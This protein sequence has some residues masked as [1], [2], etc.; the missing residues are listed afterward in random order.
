MSSLWGVHDPL[1]RVPR[2]HI[3]CLDSFQTRSDFWNWRIW[4]TFPCLCYDMQFKVPSLAD[5]YRATE[6]E[7]I[8]EKQRKR[9]RARE[10]NVPFTM[11]QSLFPSFSFDFVSLCSTR[12]KPQNQ[13]RVWAV[14]RKRKNTSSDSGDYS[15][16]G[17]EA[18][19]LQEKARIKAQGGKMFSC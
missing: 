6:M 15:Q 12:Q 9:W 16:T 7:V 3:L 10:N 11:L 1:L 14:R 8:Q 2:L 5:E 17:K 4:G 13:G 19:R 18:H